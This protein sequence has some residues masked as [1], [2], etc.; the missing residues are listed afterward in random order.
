[1]PEDG[2]TGSLFEDVAVYEQDCK[3]MKAMD[4]INGNFGKGTVKLGSLGN[5]IIKNPHEHE[6][7][8]Y[9]T[10]KEDFPKVR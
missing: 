9:T 4:A 8:H 3:L 2:V 6:S 7:P 5:G 1:M 10:K